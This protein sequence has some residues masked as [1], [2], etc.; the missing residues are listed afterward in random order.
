MSTQPFGGPQFDGII[1]NEVQKFTRTNPTE[2]PEIRWRRASEQTRDVL[3]HHPPNDTYSGRCVP[4]LNG[5]ITDAFS[6]LDQIL[7]KNLIRQT[8]HFR[9][10]HE[11]PGPKMRRL[12]SE[13]WRRLFAHEVRNN[14]QLAVKIRRLASAKA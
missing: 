8:I 2:T 4:V 6:K 11:K 12:K 1:K 5:R 3:K 14:V 7:G 9:R 13:R 10:R